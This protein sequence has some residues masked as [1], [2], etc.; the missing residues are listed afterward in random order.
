MSFPCGRM[1]TLS[2]RKFK[3]AVQRPFCLIVLIIDVEKYILEIKC[4]FYYKICS[5][6][7]SLW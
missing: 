1:G 4:A 2:T 7:F 6:R 5:E 3:H